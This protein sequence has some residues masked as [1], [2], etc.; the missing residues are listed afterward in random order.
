MKE[1]SQL[2]QVAYVRFASVYREFKDIDQ[3]MDEIKSL[4]QQRRGTLVPPLLLAASDWFARCQSRQK[5]CSHRG[6]TSVHQCRHIWQPPKPPRTTND[7]SAHQTANTRATHVAIIGAGRGGTALMEIFANDP[8]V[9]IVR[10]ADISAQAPG[11]GLA[12][13]LQFASPATT[14]NSLTM[15]PVDLVIDVSGQPEVGEYL[16]DIRRMGVP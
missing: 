10:V 2:D 7:P 1:L 16:R 14:G 5:R 4:A 15:G 11:L 9:R 13:R 8:L 3:F 12:R 6:A